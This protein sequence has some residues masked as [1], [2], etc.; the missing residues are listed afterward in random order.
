MW[1]R[2]TGDSRNRLSIR[3][4]RQWD[5]LF[6]N[7]TMPSAGW[8]ISKLLCYQQMMY[9]DVL[10]CTKPDTMYIIHLKSIQRLSRKD[11]LNVRGRLYSSHSHQ[12]NAL[13]I[14]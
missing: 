14:G 6:D 9:D 12:V 2:L 8:Y 11:V 4:T 1:F 7:L 3:L 10:K 5:Q 13:R